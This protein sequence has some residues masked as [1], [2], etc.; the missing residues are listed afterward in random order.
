LN[1]VIQNRILKTDQK[2]KNGN[3]QP[4][5]SES[6]GKKSNPKKLNWTNRNFKNQKGESPKK[7]PQ[8][9]PCEAEQKE[10]KPNC[11]RQ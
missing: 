2:T 10:K 7:K 5:L 6:K 11:L 9:L 1:R 4:N 3:L 8:K